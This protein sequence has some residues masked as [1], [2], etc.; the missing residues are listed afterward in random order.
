M[1]MHIPTCSSVKMCMQTYM[2][3][4]EVETKSNLSVMLKLESLEVGT[5]TRGDL[6]CV[7]G[8]NY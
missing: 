6:V 4:L 8:F 3:D 5:H 1:C 7:S 2:P